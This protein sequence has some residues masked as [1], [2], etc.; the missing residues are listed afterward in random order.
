MKKTIA[1]SLCAALVLAP[2]KS[3]AT[4]PTGS[5]PSDTSIM[6]ICL[7]GAAGAIGGYVYFKVRS[8]KPK[9][10]CVKDED[11]NTFPSNASRTE[12]AANDWTVQSGPYNSAEAAKA[13]CP[14][15]TNTLHLVSLVVGPSTNRLDN[16]GVYIPSISIKIWKSTN[17][18]DWVLRD[19]IL[20]DPSH[21]SWTDTNAISGNAKA[22]YRASY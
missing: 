16:P 8:C 1:L 17:L 19:T 3:I 13:A 18:V 2:L 22:F 10:Y 5:G 12:R 20:D 7:F 14:P 21:F 6:A 11:G 9:Y 4:T 15:K